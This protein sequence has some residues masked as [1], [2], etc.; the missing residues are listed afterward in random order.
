MPAGQYYVGDLCY[1]MNPQWDEFCDITISGSSVK[2]GEFQLKNGVRFA[3]LCTMY[4]D[5]C[6]EDEEGNSYAVDA[7]LI[8][9]IRVVDIN[10]SEANLKLGNIIDFKQDFDVYSSNGTLHFGHIAIETGDFD[11][12]DE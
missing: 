6:Y 7:G 9:C 4:G 3:S 2:D 1:V 10:D 8:G 11:E 12:E 5:G